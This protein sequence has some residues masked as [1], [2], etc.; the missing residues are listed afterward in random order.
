MLR[1]FGLY[2]TL[3]A[4][5]Y[6]DLFTLLLFIE[7]LHYKGFSLFTIEW[8][9]CNPLLFC[10]IVL[11]FHGNY[12]FILNGPKW[13]IY[14]YIKDILFLVIFGYRTCSLIISLFFLIWVLEYDIIKLKFFFASNIINIFNVLNIAEHIE[15]FF[16]IGILWKFRILLE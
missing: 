15:V 2:S 12:L 14:W 7:I 10:Y 8:R 5:K 6:I 11:N 4:S 13:G 9:W 16:K 1:K 3:L